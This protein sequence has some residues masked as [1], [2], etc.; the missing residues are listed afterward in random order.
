MKLDNVSVTRALG[1]INAI[2]VLVDTWAMHRD[3]N[4]AANAS[5]IGILF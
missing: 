5:I 2:N 4:H 3:V 1:D